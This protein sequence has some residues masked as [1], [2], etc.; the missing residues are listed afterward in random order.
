L[1][2]DGERPITDYTPGMRMVLMLAAVLVVSLLLF[3]GYSSTMGGR[4][5]EA[6]APAQFDP[7]T[8]AQD[9]EPLIQ[10]AADAQR[11]AL[12]QQLQ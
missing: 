4:S 10:E 2:L 7:V 5:N 1:R 6:A 12:E 8:R 3:K 11:K 9:V